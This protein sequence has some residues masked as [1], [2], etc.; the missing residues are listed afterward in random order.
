[1]REKILALLVTKFAGTRKDGLSQLARILA[2]QVAT[3]DEAKVLVDKLGKEA[4]DDFVRDFRADVD[5]EVSEA[6]RK[7]EQNLRKKEEG[8]PDPTVATGASTDPSSSAGKDTTGKDIAELI[9]AAVSEAVKPFQAEL[10]QQKASNVAKTRL[11]QLNE[12]LADCKDEILKTLVLKDFS[13]MQFNRDEEF[14]EYLSEKETAVKTANQQFNEALL[15]KQGKPAVFTTKNGE[16]LS[17][18][19]AEFLASK[20]PETP[21]SFAGKPIN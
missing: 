20:K 2:L 6:K 21:T 12:K 16:G 9:K 8:D 19:V 4:V 7:L 1:M 11:Q 13:R 15:G 3:E 10:A 5:K 17:T 18:P 14:T